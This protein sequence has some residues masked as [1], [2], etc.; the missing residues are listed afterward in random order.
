MQPLHNRKHEI[1]ALLV[2]ADF[3]P[4]EAH[5]HVGLSVDPAN[6]GRTMKRSDVSARLAYLKGEIEDQEPPDLTATSGIVTAMAAL[7]NDPRTSDPTRV[8]ALE[9]LA[10]ASL[11]NAYAPKPDEPFDPSRLSASQRELCQRYHRH[12]VSEKVESPAAI[13]M[14]RLNAMS[15]RS[16]KTA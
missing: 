5:R 3:E 15:E 9:F 1:I 7:A 4:V 2:A 13:I 16:E 8:R 12:L 6:V 14:E 11:E 10:Q